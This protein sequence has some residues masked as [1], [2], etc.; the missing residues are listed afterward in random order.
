MERR[1]FITVL[2]GAVVAGGLPWGTLGCFSGEGTR[3]FRTWTWVRDDGRRTADGWLAHFSRL[4]DAGI[5]GVLVSGRSDRAIE[6]ARS[7]GLEFQSWIWTLNRSGDAWVKENHPEW[8]TVSREGRSS[9]EYPPYVGYY[10]WI[11]PTRPGVRE[12]L[13][14][15]VER[16]AA[17]PG[18]DA[19]HLDYIRQSDVILPS[20][21]WSRYG[22][23]QDQEYPQFDFCYCEVCRE[24]FHAQSGK[25]P[26]ELSDP[27][28]D[29]EWREFRWN[30][31][32]ELVT[33][34]ADA[35]HARDRRISA[36]VFPT[37]TIA[38]NLVRQAWEQ[39]PVDA[40]FP[41]IYNTFYDQP[42]DWIGD[43]TAEGV[44][45]L[46]GR[47]PLYSGLYLPGLSPQQLGEAVVNAREAGAA[48][49]SFFESE[50]LSDDHVLVLREMLDG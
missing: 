31:L 35:V 8:F 29:V 37:P 13:K 36:A 7:A 30:T 3:G 34:L 24:V 2:S 32:T 19:V 50:G 11:C 44:T 25:D 28:S 47:R 6:A 15:V 5:S 14:A 9:L 49:V 23:V 46:D 39:W 40:V 42:V 27:P 21:L 43:A 1:R 22:L 26:L 45:A 38:R 41:M 33:I 16:I 48:G 12:Y 18:V 17:T 10:N 20:G 4:R